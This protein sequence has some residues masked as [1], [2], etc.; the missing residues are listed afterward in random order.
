MSKS[1]LA[2]L[3][4]GLAV[5]APSFA[6][7]EPLASPASEEAQL[8]ALADQLLQAIHDKS[9]AGV[10][11]LI[12][13]AG[14]LTG[15]G[16][17]P[18]GEH[19]VAHI[20]WPAFAKRIAASPQTVTERNYHPLIRVDSDLGMLWASYDVVAD[21]KRIMCGVNQFDFVRSNGTWKIL[22]VTFTRRTTNCP[23]K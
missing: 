10:L 19:R 6:A 17:S 9:E 1:H 15:A 7:V 14:G 8:S 21:G 4:I 20:D 11:A 12:D 18:T 5:A 22:N 13:P 16:I 23:A 3:L 2:I